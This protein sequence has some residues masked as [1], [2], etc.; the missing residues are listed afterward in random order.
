MREFIAKALKAVFGNF[1]LKLWAFLIALCVWFYG[2]ARMTEEITEWAKVDITPPDGYRLLWQDPNMVRVMVA[3]P[4]SL[5]TELRGDLVQNYAQFR[6]QLTPQDLRDGHATLTVDPHWLRPALPES[7]L[8]QLRFRSITPSEV[9]VYASPVKQK[10]LPVEVQATVHAAAGCRIS[11]PPDASPPQVTVR[12]PAVALDK[13]DSIRTAQLT[14]FDVESDLRRP[15]S[16]QSEVEVSLDNGVRLPVSLSVQ[17][18]TVVA[19]IYVAGEEEQERTL[20][21]VEV[22]LLA[23]PGFPYV[24]EL[25]EAEARVN[26]TLVGPPG[27]LARLKPA[28]VRAYVLLDALAGEQIV[29]GGMAP[30]KEPVRV[31]L[32]PD[33]TSSQARAEPERVTVLLKNP[34]R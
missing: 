20:E 25:G 34:A 13:M 26:V 29:P 10:E 32:P 30:Y 27:E 21:G 14:L 6:Y 24:A 16:L 18:P 15:V 22:T 28:G 12:G 7:E 4:R 31:Q 11:R 8:V 9:E 17:P 19:N 3:G 2:N 1:R 33:L 23:P 5:L